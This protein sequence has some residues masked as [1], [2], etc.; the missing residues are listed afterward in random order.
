MKIFQLFFGW[1][2]FRIGTSFILESFSVFSIH[3][4]SKLSL[5]RHIIMRHFNCVECNSVCLKLWIQSSHK[6][7]GTKI[8]DLTYIKTKTF[9][10]FS[11]WAINWRLIRLLCSKCV[12]VKDKCARQRIARFDFISIFV[13]ARNQTFN[14]SNRYGYFNTLVFWLLFILGHEHMCFIEYGRAKKW[15]FS[16]RLQ[17]HLA[18]IERHN[19]MRVFVVYEQSKVIIV[20]IWPYHI[21]T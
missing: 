15:Q 7:N 5:K 6:M 3:L 21:S 2:H 12:W 13:Y 19:E 8:S 4:I 9:I 14:S 16:T 17:Q 1:N 10:E 20:A 18:K 11:L